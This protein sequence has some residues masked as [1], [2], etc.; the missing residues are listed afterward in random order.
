MSAPREKDGP[1]V[2]VLVPTFNRRPYLA[3]ALRSLVRQTYCRFEAFIINDGGERVDDVVASFND[4]RLTL[5]DRRE[6]RGKAH[7]LNQALQHA[8]GTYVAYLDDDDLYY[9]THLA[10]LVETLQ[11]RT[12]CQAAYTDLYKVHCRVL[13]DGSRQVLGKVVNVTRDFDRFL[14][15]HFNHVLH[16]SL[17]HR[18]D[19]LERTGPYNEDLRVM[20]DWDMTRRLSFFTD[21]L[22]VPEVTGEFYGPVGECDRL[23]YRMRLNR[24]EYVRQ[25]MA[26]RASRPP[27][28]WPRMPDLSIIFL[29]DRLDAACRDALIQMCVWTFMPFEI[30][31]PL[32]AAQLA[33]L[34][35]QLANLVPVPVGEGASRAARLDAALARAQGDYA[36]VLAPGAFRVEPLWIENPLH[37]AVHHAA[38]G[39]AFAM[40]NAEGEWPAV[41]MRRTDLDRS[42]RGRRGASLR[43]SLAAAGVAV[44]APAPSELAFRFDALLQQ[45]EAMERESDWAGAARLYAQLN[46]AGANWRWMRERATW[47]LYRA[48]GHDSEVLRLC[49]GINQGQP[50]VSSLLLEAK[51]LR[52]AGDCASAAARLEDAETIL[53]GKGQPCT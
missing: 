4:P 30:Y 16:V 22:H 7:S 11:A 6:N 29:P 17:V 18:R 28:P 36:A 14:L 1:L 38:G 31:L 53:S 13:P 35:G 51:V 45:A 27:K 20:I 49:R 33:P 25:V 32:P 43:A 41:L 50:T 47:A 44:R 26:I 10:R 48:G 21:L 52:R 15:C 46:S 12:D 2:S 37:A 42:R 19:L 3:D 8:R 39:T 34:A 23:S 40:G 9:P 5:L 24:E